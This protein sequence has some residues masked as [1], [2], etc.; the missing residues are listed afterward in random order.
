LPLMVRWPSAQHSGLRVNALTQPTDLGPTLR[1]LFGGAVNAGGE[2]QTHG[3]LLALVRGREQILRRFALSGWQGD[4]GTIW[5]IRSAEWYLLLGDA[6]APSQ[7]FVKPDDR[8]EVND[9]Y[10]QHAELADEMQ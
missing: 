2:P 6:G 8:W 7:L 5:G 1:E 4:S 10:Q 3:S 9:V